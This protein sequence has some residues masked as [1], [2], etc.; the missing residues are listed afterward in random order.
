[1]FNKFTDEDIK[2]LFKTEYDIMVNNFKE[3]VINKVLLDADAKDQVRVI[4]SYL[5]KKNDFSKALSFEE[6]QKLTAY[7]A[8][9]GFSFDDI[10]SAITQLQE[11][12]SI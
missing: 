6:E 3:S 1:M 5:L 7:A 8:R 11:E 4:Q 12:R 9:K 2:D 10:R